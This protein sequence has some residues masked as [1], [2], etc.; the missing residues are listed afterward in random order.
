MYQLIQYK[1]GR[2]IIFAVIMNK[3][4]FRLNP[5]KIVLHQHLSNDCAERSYTVKL[6]I[7]R[8]SSD[9]LDCIYRNIDLIE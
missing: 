2:Y 4:D 3:Y 1:I 7:R 8:T 6:K 5:D 9:T